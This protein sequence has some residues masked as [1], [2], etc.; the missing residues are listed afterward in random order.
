MSIVGIQSILYWIFYNPVVTADFFFFLP[1]MTSKELSEENETL[2][3]TTYKLLKKYQSIR[4]IIKTLAV[5]Y[6]YI[7]I[8]QF[9]SLKSKHMNIS[10]SR[11][12][13]ISL[14]IA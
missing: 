5:S 13:S 6:R 2:T 8:F 11:L 14:F 1:E 10:V 3:N 4:T 7:H 9:I 12:F